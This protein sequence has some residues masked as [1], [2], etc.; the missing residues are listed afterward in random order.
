MIFQKFALLSYQFLLMVQNSE[1][2]SSLG[3]LRADVG[4]IL[5][6]KPSHMMAFLFKANLVFLHSV[7]S[8]PDMNINQI[9]ISKVH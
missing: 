5:K 7:P 4:I 1:V 6:E 2:M 8:G 9:I 3:G